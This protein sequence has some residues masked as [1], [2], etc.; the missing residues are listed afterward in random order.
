MID[1]NKLPYW[2]KMAMARLDEAA[3]NEMTATEIVELYFRRNNRHV[4][5]A[6]DAIEAY[7]AA[8]EA[9]AKP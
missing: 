9:G 2:V 1:L 8:V 5:W 3:V 7:K 6:R 4:V